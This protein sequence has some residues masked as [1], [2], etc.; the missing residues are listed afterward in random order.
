MSFD[1]K[2]PQR[3]KET[4]E[5][6]GSIV[7][8]PVDA[9]SKMQPISPSGNLMEEEAPLYI[10]PSPTLRSAQRIQIYNQQYWW[11]LLDSLHETYPL[12]L[13]LFGYHD[14]NKTLAVPYLM[15]YPPN[16]WSLAQVGARFPQWIEEQYSGQDKKLVLNAAKIDCAFNL[17]FL[18]SDIEPI[19]QLDTSSALSQKLYLQPHIHLF[20]MDAHLFQFRIEFLKQD[21]DYWVEHDFPNLLRE[22]TYF[23]IIYR[24]RKNDLGWN[25]ISEGEYAL[26]KQ[27]QAGISIE[28]ACQWLE[29]QSGSIYDMAVKNLHIWFQEWTARGWLI[30]R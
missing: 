12:L 18:A 10:A 26:L 25:E 15:K 16:H 30:S 28:N 24:N 19:K 14:F 9:D 27:F 20:E 1:I 6:F 3:L 4:Q 29:F 21:P 7:S 13:R 2:V 11:R 22:K 17:C 8:R 5:W 23:F